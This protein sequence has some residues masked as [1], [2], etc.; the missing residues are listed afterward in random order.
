[1]ASVLNGS[2][3]TAK[4]VVDYSEPVQYIQRE[5]RASFTGGEIVNDWRQYTWTRTAPSDAVNGTLT[6]S[7]YA[8]DYYGENFEVWVSI[9]LT[10]GGQSDSKI[11]DR[12]WTTETMSN[13]SIPTVV[14]SG[15]DFRVI[16]RWRYSPDS[17]QSNPPSNS[18]YGGIRFWLNWDE[19]VN[20]NPTETTALPDSW[21][22]DTTQTSATSATYPTTT[23]YDLDNIGTDIASYDPFSSIYQVPATWLSFQ[24]VLGKVTSYIPW[25]ITV[26][27]FTMV[28][29]IL[30]W[31]L[32]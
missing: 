1:M 23:I 5:A 26:I 16:F 7:D 2:T 13:I 24:A 14:T 25:V 4:A 28:C 19:A 27:G 15:R 6:F 31:L 3:L 12:G 20:Y 11:F 10:G 18:M 17:Q 9:Y 32:K 22:Q 29:S 30:W 21:L 8:V